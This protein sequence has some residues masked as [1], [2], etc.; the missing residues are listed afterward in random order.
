MLVFERGW[1][2][3]STNFRGKGG[4]FTNE[5][6]R[7]KTRL[8][9]LSCGVVCVILSLAILIQYRRVTH[10]H[11]HTDGH[12][13]MAITRAELGSVRVK[14]I[15]PDRW[16]SSMF[17]VQYHSFDTVGWETRR[18][19][20]PIIAKD[21]LFRDSAKHRLTPQQEGCLNRPWR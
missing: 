21:Y 11:R 5:F 18:A 3:L 4:S 16:F 12:T 8:P 17:W 9:G 15:R 2:T 6:W 19:F 10:I 14:R 13:M 7:Q 20:L 1:V